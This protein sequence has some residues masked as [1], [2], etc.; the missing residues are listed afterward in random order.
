MQISFH[1]SSFYRENNINAWS[2]LWYFNIWERIVE[3]LWNHFHFI[4][5][6]IYILL[7]PLIAKQVDVREKW[8]LIFLVRGFVYFSMKKKK[9]SLLWSTFGGVGFVN[10]NLCEVKWWSNNIFV[11]NAK[12]FRAKKQRWVLVFLQQQKNLGTSIF[13]ILWG[14]SMYT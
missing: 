12:M 2:T 13:T 14:T 10:S 1:C 7:S 11:I 4:C 5:T 6:I 9:K 3:W 8:L